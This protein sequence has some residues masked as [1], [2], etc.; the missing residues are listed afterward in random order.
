M[1]PDRYRFTH[2]ISLRYLTPNTTVAAV[3]A[4][5]THHKIVTGLN[6]DR[7][8]TRWTAI[9]NLHQVTIGVG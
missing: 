6:D 9:I 7:K 5:I 8:I 1:H 3:V 4:I 2:N